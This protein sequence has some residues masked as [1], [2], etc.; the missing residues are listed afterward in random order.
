[1]GNELTVA[2]HQPNF[3]PWIGYFYKMYHSDIF[4]LGD[5]VQYI[6]KGFINRNIIKTPQGAKWLTVPVCQR[7][8]SLISDI[9]IDNRFNWRKKHLR[10]F[11]VNYKRTKFFSEF[12]EVLK[13]VY[14]SQEWTSLCDFNISLI[15]AILSYLMIDKSLIKASNLNVKGERTDLI[16]DIVKSVRGTIYL[17]GYGGKKYQNEQL[18]EKQ[19]IKLKYYDFVHPVYN[20]LWGDFIPNCSIIDLLFNYGTESSMIIYNSN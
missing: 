4:I 15:K 1:M 9:K 3:L 14:N 5:N 10:T 6:R 20:Q 16:I 19:E 18:L 11:E 12:F 17:S 13:N 7:Y 8:Q 2:V